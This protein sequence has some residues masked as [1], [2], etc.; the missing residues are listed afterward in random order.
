MI[1]CKRCGYEGI[2]ESKNCPKC[3]A[4]LTVDESGIE[5]LRREVKAAILSG[6]SDMIIESYRAL[7]LAGDT[8]GERE[9]A[10]LLEKGNH[11]PRD[12]NLATD[13]FL[14]A[15]EKCDGYS[16]YRYSRLISRT[17]DEHSRFWLLFSAMLDCADAY[18][19]AAEEYSRLGEDEKAPLHGW[20][21]GCDECQTVCPYNRKAPLAT[22]PH[23]APLFDP[24]AMTTDE[25]LS[26]SEEEF[27]A[28]FS[29][30]PLERAGLERLKEN[31]SR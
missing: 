20:I 12:I 8:E 22:N 27:S 17:S 15:A 1:K 26:L 30:T 23:F 31:L 13:F 4:P 19:P 11:T 18:A 21:F 16:A 6:E 9:Y 25:W 10:K 5:K 2:F 3:S 28:K 29:S 7:A 14:R 24:V